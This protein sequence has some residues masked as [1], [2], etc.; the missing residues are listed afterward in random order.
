MAACNGKGSENTT[1]GKNIR[2]SHSVIS[3]VQG[4]C[5]KELYETPNFHGPDFVSAV[6]EISCNMEIG[7]WWFWC[8]NAYDHDCFDLEH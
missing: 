6:E 3:S 4:H 8:A 7:K 5:A 1:A 2:A